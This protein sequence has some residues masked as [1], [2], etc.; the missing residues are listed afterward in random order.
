MNNSNVSMSFIASNKL[1]HEAY[2]MC[3]SQVEELK[4]TDFTL[5]DDHTLPIYG[6]A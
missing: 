2:K 1:K 5:M 6:T 3:C 4:L